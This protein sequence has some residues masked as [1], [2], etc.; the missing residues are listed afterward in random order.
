[1]LLNVDDLQALFSWLATDPALAM[2]KRWQEL[3]AASIERIRNPNSIFREGSRNI[4]DS[5]A[6]PTTTVNARNEGDDDVDDESDGELDVEAPIVQPTELHSEMLSAELTGEF[7]SVFRE[8]MLFQTIG[9]QTMQTYKSALVWYH[10]EKHAVWSI[11]NDRF[12]ENFISGYE[13]VI[14]EKKESGVMRMQ[15][16]KSHLSWDGYVK[17]CESLI[18]TT[19]PNANMI[20]DVVDATQQRVSAG[21]RRRVEGNRNV[22]RVSWMS[23]KFTHCFE[24]LS[25]N[26][27]ARSKSIGV[28]HF[29]H[30]DWK[31]DCLSVKF[32]RT[33]KD[34]TGKSC[35]HDRHIYANPLQPSVCP[36]LSLAV[37]V[38][39][40][41]SRVETK[42]TTVYN[43]LTHK[44][45]ESFN[46]SDV[47]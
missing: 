6:L 40:N 47:E 7:G 33:K 10:S 41:Q 24:T 43:K 46:D 18:E 16:G 3:P 2:R 5:V 34:R 27:M 42:F 39:C 22:G 25:W 26:L 44:A 13:K 37:Y 29:S 1:M 4:F 14:A 20:V 12:C 30:F 11:E 21:K 15:E 9:V 38:L 35:K 17:I 32:A 45:T 19:D 31:E 36:I 28:L 8:S 23:N